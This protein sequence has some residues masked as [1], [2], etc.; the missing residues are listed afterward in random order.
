MYISIFSQ[1][2]YIFSYVCHNTTYFGPL[3][4]HTVTHGSEVKG[5]LVDVVGS[6]YTSHW[7]WGESSPLCVEKTNGELNSVRKH[8]YNIM[9]YGGIY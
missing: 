4:W 8:N 6:R 3:W 1:Y 9:L 5:K 7:F 2:N